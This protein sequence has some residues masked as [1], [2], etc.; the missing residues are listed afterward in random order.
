MNK[1]TVIVILCVTLGLVEA[2]RLK[3]SYFPNR[4]R[5]GDVL[6]TRFEIVNPS[7]ATQTKFSCLING[8]PLKLTWLYIVIHGH[9]SYV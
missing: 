9:V 2:V 3:N 5:Y 4:L 6:R 1:V 7:G 8:R